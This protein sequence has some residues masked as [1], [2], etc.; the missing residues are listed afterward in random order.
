MQFGW[1]GRLATLGP[2]QQQ[3]DPAHDRR[4][5]A[6][7]SGSDMIFPHSCST[8]ERRGCVLTEGGSEKSTVCRVR[9]PTG[10]GGLG[11]GQ[12]PGRQHG[13]CS[14][15][16]THLQ[17]PLL[18]LWLPR[19]HGP[20]VFEQAGRLGHPAAGTHSGHRRVVHLHD[21]VCTG[22]HGGLLGRQPSQPAGQPATSQAGRQC[23]PVQPTSAS[24]A[25]CRT[26]GGPG[27]GPP[28]PAAQPAAAPRCHSQHR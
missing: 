25:C 20:Q 21:V 1:A 8:Q 11:E 14:G 19:H 6:H 18:V 17:Q 4:S 28:H 5:P 12:K 15:G 22:A 26:R 9:R 3:V 16:R 24:C 13:A 23:S 27:R 7:L 10:R 2:R